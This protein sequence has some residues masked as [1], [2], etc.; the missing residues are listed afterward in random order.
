MLEFP[1]SKI[2]LF[3]DSTYRSFPLFARLDLHPC[4][5]S[6]KTLGGVRILLFCV[7]AFPFPYSA[8]CIGLLARRRTEK[9]PR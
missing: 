3:S 9:N 1:G 7:I 8:G 6:I 4:F 2:S 5:C